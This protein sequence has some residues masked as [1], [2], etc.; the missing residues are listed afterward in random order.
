MSSLRDSSGRAPVD[1]PVE[2]R[3]AP[4]ER[5]FTIQRIVVGGVIGALV[6]AVIVLGVHVS[7]QGGRTT[8]TTGPT[9][10]NADVYDGIA[11]TTKDSG[12]LQEDHRTMR[13]VSARGDLTDLRELAWPADS[14]TRIGSARCT[15]NFRFNRQAA[16]GI[17]PT[18]LICWRTS[19]TKSVYT[20]VSDLVDKPSM[21]ASVAV[22]ERE[23]NSMG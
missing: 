7:Q 1:T 2:G 12:N 8:A 20:V 9:S 5:R 14:G 18:L 22:L 21:Q 11:V 23:W 6:I 10:T 3:A 15:Q 16:P 19:A 4:E 13:I 17:R